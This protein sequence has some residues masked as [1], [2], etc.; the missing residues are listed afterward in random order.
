M[1]AIQQRVWIA[2]LTGSLISV[3]LYFVSY[4][5]PISFLFWLQIVGFYASMVIL[6]VHRATKTD[7]AMIAIPINA[8]VYA[9][10][11]FGFMRIFASKKTSSRPQ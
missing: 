7:F 5:F 11:I 3:A 9:V 6:G 2:A 4:S 8:A 1:N 10:A